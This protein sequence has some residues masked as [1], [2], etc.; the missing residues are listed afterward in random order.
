RDARS[1]AKR[2]RPQADGAR[3][4]PSLPLSG[5]NGSFLRAASNRQSFETRGP[6]SKTFK[7]R[8]THA[9]SH[10][11]EGDVET[12]VGEAAHLIF[13]AGGPF[14]E[15]DALIHGFGQ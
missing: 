15:D 2:H 9:F 7:A 11:S 10:E 14:D 8:M 6:A 3:P 12:V 5:T 4:F 1:G 13:R